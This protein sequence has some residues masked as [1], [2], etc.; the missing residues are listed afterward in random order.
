HESFGFD[1][2]FVQ[3]LFDAA[4]CGGQRVGEVGESGRLNVDAGGGLGDGLRVHCS[5]I[6]SSGRPGTG[7]ARSA[8][9]CRP[10]T[11]A[12]SSP[13]A[14]DAASATRRAAS[15]WARAMVVTVS[16]ASSAGASS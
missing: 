12:V 9:A 1:I 8:S 3:F 15:C 11:R 2:E 6:L 7:K 10:R 13:K 16:C 14:A 4:T 5:V